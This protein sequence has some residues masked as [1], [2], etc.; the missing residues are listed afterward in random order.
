[1]AYKIA[2]AAGF[3]DGEGSISISRQGTKKADL[4][5]LRCEVTNTHRG[6]LEIF[7]NLFGGQIYERALRNNRKRLYIW[8]GVGPVGA[9]M[10]EDL[11]PYLV[12]KKERAVLAISFQA[13]R[14]GVGRGGRHTPEI[15]KRSIRDH[16]KMQKL[17]QRGVS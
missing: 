2:W 6:S 8:R 5:Y 14:A 1:M 13:D 9:Q 4:F 11:L 10:L 15:K 3:F 16:A 12:V 17:N 7:Q